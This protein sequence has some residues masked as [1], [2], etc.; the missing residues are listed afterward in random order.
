MNGRSLIGGAGDASSVP[1]WRNPFGNKAG[2]AMRGGFSRL[3]LALARG[4]PEQV[5]NRKWAAW[6][7]RHPRGD[8]HGD[9]F[10]QWGLFLV[11]AIPCLSDVHDLSNFLKWV[12]LR[13]QQMGPSYIHPALQY[14][15]DHVPFSHR[16]LQSVLPNHIVQTHYLGSQCHLV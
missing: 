4:P 8:T 16:T 11:A 15:I 14:G 2:E 1:L 10:Q 5:S 13:V 9:L 6:L 12:E 3:K 7:Q